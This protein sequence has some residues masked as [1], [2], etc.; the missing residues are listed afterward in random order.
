M[1]GVFAG[2]FGENGCFWDGFWW[3]FCGES[4]VFLWLL[5]THFPATK[6]TPTFRN[7]FLAILQMRVF[8]SRF[9]IPLP[10]SREVKL[11]GQLVVHLGRP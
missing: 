9:G 10:C 2:V 7:I 6:N 11:V 1:R 3:C 8:F 4:V 5:E